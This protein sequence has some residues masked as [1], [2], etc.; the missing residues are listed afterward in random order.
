MAP[1][2][3]WPVRTTHSSLFLQLAAHS[4]ISASKA[5]PVPELCVDESVEPLGR[6]LIARSVDR[7]GLAEG[8][9]VRV[10]VG[11]VH[12]GQGRYGPTLRVARQDDALVLV[13]AVGGALPYLGLEGVSVVRLVGHV[14]AAAGRAAPFRAG[15][16]VIDARLGHLGVEVLGG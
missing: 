11:Q 15:G 7:V 10:E 9:Y 6:D 14:V 8:D 1:P 5:S 16:G 2:C 4:R 13:L 3:E 12:G